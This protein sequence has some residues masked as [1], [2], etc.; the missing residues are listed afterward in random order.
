M[1]TSRF[2]PALMSSST[3]L[4]R[5]RDKLGGEIG[6]Q[7]LDPQAF[8]LLLPGVFPEQSIGENLADDLKTAYHHHQSKSLL[9]CNEDIERA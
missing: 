3:L 9:D 5:H 2:K 7:P 4:G 6:N 8:L 1:S